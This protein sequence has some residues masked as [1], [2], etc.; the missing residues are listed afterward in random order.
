MRYAFCRYVLCAYMYY[1][2]CVMRYA[3]CVMRCYVLCICIM[4]S[5]ALLCVVMRRYA[6]LCV[7]MLGYACY[8][9][10]FVMRLV[11]MR[12]YAHMH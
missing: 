1:E 7:V 11:F 9:Y 3:L 2:L 10:F 8:A 12:R 4:R 5:Y 6:L